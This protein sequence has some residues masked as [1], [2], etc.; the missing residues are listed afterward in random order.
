[1]LHDF[2]ISAQDGCLYQ[3]RSEKETIIYQLF[4]SASI[5]ICIYQLLWIKSNANSHMTR[6][7]K[8]AISYYKNEGS[9]H[10]IP[11]IDTLKMKDYWTNNIENNKTSYT[12]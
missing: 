9:Y 4:I 3:E 8:N 1:L 5:I 2:N 6:F 12:N 10:L 11:H 7:R